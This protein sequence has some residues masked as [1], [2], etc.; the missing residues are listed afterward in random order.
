M[1]RSYGTPSANSCAEQL[2]FGD[3]MGAAV[4]DPLATVNARPRR[5]KKFLNKLLEVRSASSKIVPEPAGSSSNGLSTFDM[6]S[7]ISATH[8]TAP[9]AARA[10]KATPGKSATPADASDAAPTG[11]RRQLPSLSRAPHSDGTLP[12]AASPPRPASREQWVSPFARRQQ[13]RGFTACD[14][15]RDLS[16][17][18]AIVRDLGRSNAAAAYAATP[19]TT[20]APPV[21]AGARKPAE[22]RGS[23][24]NAADAGKRTSNGGVPASDGGKCDAPVKAADAS[25]SDNKSAADTELGDTSTWVTGSDQASDKP[26]EPGIDLIA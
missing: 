17:G 24:A 11:R 7:D 4:V 23:G 26:S 10:P 9:A 19:S 20:P 13:S 5:P 25:K 15:I 1:D 18:Q 16:R 22:V 8:P 14:F 12:R 6:P 2:L 21:I 3:A